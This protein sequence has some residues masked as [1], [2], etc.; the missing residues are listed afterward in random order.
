MISCSH[1]DGL[2]RQLQ[3]DDA[4]VVHDAVHRANAVD[5]QVGQ[6]A[7]QKFNTPAANHLALA[8]ATNAD[9]ARSMPDRLSTALQPEVPQRG[10]QGVC[11]TYTW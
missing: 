5:A 4:S 10:K 8:S 6:H 3:R 11:W 1:G 9:H 2:Q 7:P